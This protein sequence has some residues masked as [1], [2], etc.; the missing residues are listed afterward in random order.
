VIIRYRRKPRVLIEK[1]SGN[2]H[3]R[4]RGTIRFGSTARELRLKKSIVK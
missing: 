4:L 3:T 2:F 1:K